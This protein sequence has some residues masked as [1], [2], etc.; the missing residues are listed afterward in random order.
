MNN[1]N[2]MPIMA[3]AQD[4]TRLHSRLF[5]T[6]Y[7]QMRVIMDDDGALVGL[8]L[9]NGHSRW[10]HEV[11]EQHYNI[12]ESSPR[13]DA[14]LMQLDEYF[15]GK[16]QHFDVRLNLIGT[17]FQKEVWHTLTSI[18]YGATIS[19]LELARRIGNPAA[20]RAVGAANGR[21]PIPII[22]PCHRVIGADGSLT[23][24]GGGL[25]LKAALLKL[26]GVSIPH[27]EQLRLL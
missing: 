14:I 11:L 22:V 6:P 15:A 26:E 10:D 16:R 2:S 19:Y 18:Q 4:P 12:I 20:V 9:P 3:T 1:E 17:D 13:C 25:H 21:N 23:G 7:G 24:F 5:N 8:I 27:G